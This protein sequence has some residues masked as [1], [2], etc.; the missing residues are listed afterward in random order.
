MPQTVED[1]HRKQRIA[2]KFEEVVI[3]ANALDPEELF[4]DAGKALLQRGSGRD[5]LGL[6]ER[7]D[8][9]WVRERPEVE[10]PVGIER[11][12]IHLDEALREHVDGQALFQEAA[13]IIAG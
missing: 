6:E 12:L 10:L 4:P 3:D 7:S 5:P 11:Q 9:R 8:V 1:L 2:A 13:Q